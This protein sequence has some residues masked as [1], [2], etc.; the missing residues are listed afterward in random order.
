MDTVGFEVSAPTDTAACDGRI[1]SE[2]VSDSVTARPAICL[3]MIVRNEAH[4]VKE[5]LNSIAPYISSWVIVDTGSDDGTQALIADH[6]AGLGRPGKLYERPWR[7]FGDNRTEALTLAQGHGDYIWVVDADDILVGTP[8]FTRLSAEIYLLRHQLGTDIYWRPELFRDGV[9]ARWVGVT[10]ECVAWDDA[11]VSA[12]LEGEYHIQNRQLSSHNLSGEK[13]ARDH[14]LLLAEVER[15][16]GNARSVF[17]LAQSYFT[18]GDFANARNWYERRAEMGG[19]DE[20]VYYSLTQVAAAIAHQGGP[21]PDIQDALLRSWEVRPTRAEPLYQ[22]AVHYRVEQHHHLGYLFAE[23]AARIPL[24]ESDRLFVGAD[25]YAWRAIDEQAVCASWIGKHAEAFMLCRRLL[26]R[27]DIPDGRRRAIAGNRDLSV[28]A[29]IEAAS[30]Y[31]DELVGS[32][33]AG[34]R[35]AA[36]TVTLSAGPDRESTEQTLNSFLHC[37]T[38]LSQVG[39]FVVVDAGLSAQDRMKLHE[40][41]KFLEFVDHSQA[42]GPAAQLQ[43]LRK[44][45]GGRFWLHLGQG[46]R[47]FA[48]ENYIARLTAVLDAEP[49]V[50]QVGVN[51]ADAVQPSGACAA[52]EAVRRTSDGGRYVLADGMVSGPAMFDTARLDQ[53]G[54]VDSADLDPLAALGRRAAAAG[55][56]IA[57]LDEV[58]CQGSSASAVT[59]RVEVAPPIT[60]SPTNT[61]KAP[62]LIFAGHSHLLAIAGQRI[63]GRPLELIADSRGDGTFIM[64]GP[65]PDMTYWDTLADLGTDADVGI[66]WGGNEHNVCYFFE[67]EPRFDF[68][69]AQVRKMNP[70]AQIMPRAAIR[71]RFQQS[72]NDLDLVLTRLAT[73]GLNR[74]AL[75]G[76]PPPKRDNEALRAFAQRE[77][78]FVSAAARFGQSVETLPITDPYVR[79]KLWHLLQDMLADTARS[80]GVMFIAVPKQVQDAD[81][82]LQREFWFPDVTHANEAYGN[83]IY[84]TVARAFR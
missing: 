35:D 31:P 52:E 73:A 36:V 75:I 20:E 66:I 64:A 76:T 56:G 50:F 55:M 27:A 34:P 4:V 49:Q 48:P 72:L 18:L 2:V 23:R 78:F 58:L 21:W 53:V 29:M 33:V 16:P 40:R 3:A 5:A 26:A 6:M 69:S 9:C 83:V 84:E 71:H 38:D 62:R 82:F 19:W 77:E 51:F 79:L 42:D 80:R 17:C 54:G 81:G 37:C 13:F 67:S 61:G 30:S 10:Y 44:Q 74:I 1:R 28:P 57:S 45:I 32:T 11:H 14:D 12:R 68:L 70:S 24:P 39:R 25:V 47:F 7:N 63:F 15:N 59:T 41:Y 60:S 8:D 46:W 22:I 65:S 43:K